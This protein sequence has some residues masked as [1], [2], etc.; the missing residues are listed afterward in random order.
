MVEGTTDPLNRSNPPKRSLDG[1]RAVGGFQK[2][3][4]LV[5]VEAALGVVQQ[6]EVLLDTRVFWKVGRVWGVFGFRGSGVEG[7]ESVSFAA[8]RTWDP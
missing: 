1:F 3:P 5:E 4:S 8:W 2:G 6:P 7:G